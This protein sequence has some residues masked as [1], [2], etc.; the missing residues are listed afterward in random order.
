MRDGCHSDFAVYDLHGGVFEW[1]SSAFRRGASDG[2][3]ALRG[4]NGI[5]G[6]LV[7]RCANAEPMDPNRRSEEIGFRC[8][9]GP[10]NAAAVV[11]AASRGD[12]IERIDRPS[13]AQFRRLFGQLR[14]E[15]A[16]ELVDRKL[17]LHRAF[18]WRP[19]SNEQLVVFTACTDGPLPHRCGLLVGRDSPAHPTA[20][21]W[22][23][24]GYVPSSLHMDEH[25]ES[26]W[27]IGLDAQGRFKRQVRYQAGLVL[28]GPIERRI[29]AAKKTTKHSK[30]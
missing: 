27:L 6:E 24:T 25:S 22:A 16:A 5:A 21:G 26:I 20:L 29:P 30:R 9:S 7:G 8:C 18:I 17:L 23:G 11:I 2:K 1:T 3:V 13:D 15:D 19:I 28:V 4:G 14:S 10:E 12:A